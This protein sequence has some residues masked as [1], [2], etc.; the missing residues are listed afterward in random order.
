MTRPTTPAAASDL[1]TLYLALAQTKGQFPTGSVHRSAIWQAMRIVKEARTQSAQPSG[2][3][4]DR[5]VGYSRM[6]D[7]SGAIT[8]D[9]YRYLVANGQ[10]D[11][12]MGIVLVDPRDAATIAQQGGG[13][14]KDAVTDQLVAECGEAYFFVKGMSWDQ[15]SMR[16]A[17]EAA[18]STRPAESVAQGGEGFRGLDLTGRPIYGRQAAFVTTTTDSTTPA[19]GSGGEA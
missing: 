1:E 7:G 4:G 5:I 15:K 13:E 12:M 11:G 10:G 19:T 18:F 8:P 17:I 3:A 16:A 2:M 9:E 6:P 14:T